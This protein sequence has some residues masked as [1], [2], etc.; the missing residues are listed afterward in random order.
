MWSLGTMGN[1]TYLAGGFGVMHSRDISKPSQGGGDDGSTVNSQLISTSGLAED[2]GEAAT[3][4]DGMLSI[5]L[6]TYG[7]IPN[8]SDPP[9]YSFG[10]RMSD[11][12]NVTFTAA[13]D[14][15]TLN[16]KANGATT[17]VKGRSMLPE[18]SR[19]SRSSVISCRPCRA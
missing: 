2:A 9:V 12:R 4:A 3:L 11:G 8:D 13:F 16:E 10:E 18:S 17:D 1:S 5:K 14:L 15:K 7:W 6:P 19:S